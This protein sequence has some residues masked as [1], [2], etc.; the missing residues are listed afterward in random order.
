[1]H[2]VANINL[3]AR[4]NIKTTSHLLAQKPKT[5]PSIYNFSL[6]IITRQL[7]LISFYNIGYHYVV[8]YDF[9]PTTKYALRVLRTN[10]YYLRRSLIALDNTNTASR[11]LLLP[12]YRLPPPPPQT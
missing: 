10:Y 5:R 6:I 2:Y 4:A 12:L 7:I 9:R 8:M 1:M 3:S 11:V